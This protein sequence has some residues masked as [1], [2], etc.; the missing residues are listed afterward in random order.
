MTRRIMLT[1]LAVT[2][3]AIIAFSVPAALS[4]RGAQG[5][6]A[7]LALQREASIVASRVPPAGPIDAAAL[8]VDVDPDHPL[9]FYGPDGRLVWGE[10]PA[11]ADRVVEI[12]LGGD[13]AEGRV[14]SDLVAAVPVRRLSDGSQVVFRIEAPRSEG[15][16]RFVRSLAALGAAAAVVVASAAAVAF[17]LARRLNRPIDQLRTWASDSDAPPPPPTGIAEIDDLRADIIEGRTRID[18]LLRRERSFSSDVSHQLR[19]PVAAMRVAIETELTAPRDESTVVLHE[20][21]DQL[22]RLESTITSLLNLARHDRRRPEPVDLYALMCER[23]SGWASMAAVV[24]RSV[25]VAGGPVTVV[26]DPDAIGHIADVLVDNALR[27]GAG[28]VV[29]T[30]HAEPGCVLVDVGDDGAHAAGL[31]VFGGPSPDT[32]HG[33]GLR[34]ANSLAAA[35]G[36]ELSLLDRATTT[37]RIA[38]PHR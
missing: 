17:Q 26:T 32:G 5:D 29:V 36:A 25:Q 11:V 18:D 4:I 19:T 27:H 6:R 16:A 10:G 12:A 1:V 33:L 2:V 31:V 35:I 30:V 13:F 24:G 34:L 37:I 28:S 21:L 22:D 7:V 20:S 3:L 23:R 9:S 15:R 14:G 8:A 38:V